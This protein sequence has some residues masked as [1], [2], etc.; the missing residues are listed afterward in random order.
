MNVSQILV[1]LFAVIA[2]SFSIWSVT[3]VIRYPIFKL[4]PLW[5]IGCLFGFIGLGINWTT[6]D[7]LFLIF[8]I[9]IPVVTVFKVATGQVIVKTGFPIVSAV[10]L[11]IARNIIL[12][13]DG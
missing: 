4:K 12:P 8:G 11:Y 1:V 7:N 6:P 10:A 2:A 13:N 9:T 3:V 5:V